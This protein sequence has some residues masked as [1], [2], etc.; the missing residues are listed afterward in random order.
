MHM[1]HCILIMRQLW[2]KWIFN[3]VLKMESKH[4]MEVLKKICRGQ[5]FSMPAHT[6]EIYS[7]CKG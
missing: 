1:S 6:Q 3:R 4:V 2:L 5:L 7:L